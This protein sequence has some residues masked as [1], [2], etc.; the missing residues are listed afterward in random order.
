MLEKEIYVLRVSPWNGRMKRGSKAVNAFT[1]GG[2]RMDPGSI[3]AGCTV[4]PF[5]VRVILIKRET[6]L[7]ETTIIKKAQY[8][9]PRWAVVDL[10]QPKAWMCRKEVWA[11]A[12]ALTESKDRSDLKE[13]GQAV[14]QITGS[15]R[16]L[17]NHMEGLSYED[18]PQTR[19]VALHLGLEAYSKERA[20]RGE[21]HH[22]R[23]SGTI[24]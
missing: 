2:K 18:D 24:S 13:I 17:N 22:V 12:K 10:L 14:T 3:P 9:L 7:S 1:C 5:P 4:V 16:K 6:T 11:R 19:T 15:F 20:R 23:K 21:F 8:H